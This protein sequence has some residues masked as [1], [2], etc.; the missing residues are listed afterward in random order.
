[1]D[2][3]SA[4]ENVVRMIFPSTMIRDGELLPAAFK[5]RE[6]NDESEKYLSVFRQ[7]HDKFLQDV[8]SFDKQRNLP[9]CIL[10]VGEVNA[11][12]L[13]I[14]GNTVKYVVNA[15]PTS[16]YAS[17]AGI[18]ISIGGILLEGNGIVAFERLEIGEEANFHLIAIRRR[19]VEI[20]KKRMTSVSQLLETQK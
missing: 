12:E 10:N 18:F 2:S 19:L 1:M 6:Q 20:A 11:V 17:H 16:T 13:T 4:I 5:L 14:A 7:Y 9:C 8:V 3:L 15:V